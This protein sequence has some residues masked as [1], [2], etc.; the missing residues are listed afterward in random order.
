[1]RFFRQVDEA[2]FDSIG[3]RVEAHDFVHGG[4]VSGHAVES[5]AF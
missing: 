4:R 2:I 5:V 3:D 1:V